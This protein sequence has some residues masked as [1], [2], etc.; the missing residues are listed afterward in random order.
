MSVDKTNRNVA[1]ISKIFYI[2]AS[3]KDAAIDPDDVSNN[4]DIYNMHD[5]NDH[6]F[7]H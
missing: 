1:F 2:K 6:S 5:I 4:S 3:I 7:N